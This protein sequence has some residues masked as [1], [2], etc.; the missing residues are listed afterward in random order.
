MGGVSPGW[1]SLLKEEGEGDGRELG[2]AEG[3]GRHD[4]SSDPDW[5]E[6]STLQIKKNK[7]K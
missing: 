2:E 1:P 6:V 4:S 3:E 5:N 7:K